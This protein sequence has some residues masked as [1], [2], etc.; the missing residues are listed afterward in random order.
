MSPSRVLQHT[1]FP[2]F[3]DS[4][5]LKHLSLE[6][7]Y[8]EL[9]PDDRLEYRIYLVNFQKQQK[10]LPVGLQITRET[11]LRWGAIQL[12]C[13]FNTCVGWLVPQRFERTKNVCT[14]KTNLQNTEQ[15]KKLKSCLQLQGHSIIFQVPNSILKTEK[16]LNE[17]CSLN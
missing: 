2:F 12:L 15:N 7:K 11:F 17:M 5:P 13:V 9:K 16:A 14:V 8:C 10:F 6:A 1:G 4:N 3:S